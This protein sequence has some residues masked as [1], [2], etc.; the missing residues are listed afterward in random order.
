MGAVKSDLDET[1]T[2]ASVT[3]N[4]VRKL[5]SE[6]L[7]A[8]NGEKKWQKLVIFGVFQPILEAEMTLSFDHRVL[9]GGAAG[10][11]LSR[12]NALMTQPS[13]L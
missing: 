7:P 3:L 12:I 10:R 6:L 2:K 9:D 1:F 11:L 13:L 8:M 4:L 5:F